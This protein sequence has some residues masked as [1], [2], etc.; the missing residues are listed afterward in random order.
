[1]LLLSLLL[2]LHLCV[3]MSGHIFSHLQLMDSPDIVEKSFHLCEN[4]CWPGPRSSLI[5][6][7]FS[8]SPSPSPFPAHSPL[9]F[10]FFSPPPL[11]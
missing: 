9:L 6:S 10:F 4:I 11:G 3:L 1:M 2:L 8:P 7:P 5:Y